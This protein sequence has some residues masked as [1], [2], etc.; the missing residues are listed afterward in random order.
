MSIN[1]ELLE[2]FKKNLPAHANESI[3]AVFEENKQLQSNLDFLKKREE[4]LLEKVRNKEKLLAAATA[5]N[6]L[7]QQ[8]VKTKEELDKD[9]AVLEAQQRDLDL[10]ILKAKYEAL[11][12]SK[13]EI[14]GLVQAVFRNPVIKKS[15]IT[16]VATSYTTVSSEYNSTTGN[17]DNIPLTNTSVDNYTTETSEEI[18]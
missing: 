11:T 10:T 1:Q 4:E 13:E 7:L 17:Y 6:K 15:A 3:V 8:R 16:P 12:E 5:E 9:F 18:I 2:V 14:K